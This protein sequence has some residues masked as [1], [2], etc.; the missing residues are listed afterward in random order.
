MN[1]KIF[2][3]I[4]IGYPN[5]NRTRTDPNQNLEISKWDWNLWSRKPE[6]RIDPN[7][8]R[9]GTRTPTPRY[10]YLENKNLP[11]PSCQTRARALIRKGRTS[12]KPVI[13]ITM[14]WDHH[15][16]KFDERDFP[17]TT[18]QGWRARELKRI[19]LA[20]QEQRL[21][22]LLHSHITKTLCFSNG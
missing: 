18:S 7:R 2:K 14:R 15:Y 10:Y 8:T 16:N 6:T 3:I 17:Q 9:M 13:F 11:P 19:P 4:L 12:K 22:W 21:W 20:Q 1:F 5:L